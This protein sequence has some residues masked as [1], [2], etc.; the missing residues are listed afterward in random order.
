VHAAVTQEIAIKVV[1]GPALVQAITYYDKQG[2]NQD[3]PI[4]LAHEKYF[5][6]KEKRKI[7]NK[8]NAI[9]ATYQVVQLP[10]K[11]ALL[12]SLSCM[13]PACTSKPTGEYN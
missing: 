8:R 4:Q 12:L 5:V 7:S 1:R 9:T 13:L 2:G 6:N 3:Y 11:G 10:K